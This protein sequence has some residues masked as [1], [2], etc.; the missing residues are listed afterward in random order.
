LSTDKSEWKLIDTQQ[1][2]FS[3]VDD[4]YENECI[5]MR[6][7]TVRLKT[8]AYVTILDVLNQ[9]VFKKLSDKLKTNC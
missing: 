1:M 9:F 5:I 7:K 4:L 8:D 3:S 6:C 2:H